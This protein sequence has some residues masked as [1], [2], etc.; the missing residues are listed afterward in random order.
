MPLGELPDPESDSGSSWESVRQQENK[1]TDLALNTI[2]DSTSGHQ[3]QAQGQQGQTGQAN[4]Q[5]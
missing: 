3:G 1:W 5:I 2:S 4:A